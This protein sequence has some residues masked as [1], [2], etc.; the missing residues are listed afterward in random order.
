MNA[1]PG[2]VSGRGDD[3]MSP[4]G[5]RRGD[6]LILPLWLRIGVLATVL[7][8]LLTVL[9]AEPMS[10]DEARL[11]RGAPIAQ[12]ALF[13]E[14]DPDGVIRVLDAEAARPQSAELL[15]LQPGEDGFI[16]SVMRGLAL[17]RKSR[18]IGPADPFLLG[19]FSDGRLYIDDPATGR[20]VV[21]TAFGQDNVRAFARLLPGA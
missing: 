10:A 18:G 8:A 19:A 16:R 13:F 14:D 2:Q 3:R 4:D 21:V 15:R 17:E 5:M 11:E 20:Q 9:L 1:S 6:K 7:G 12:R